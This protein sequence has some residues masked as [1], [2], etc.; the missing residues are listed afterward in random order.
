MIAEVVND[1]QL[2]IPE[3]VTGTGGPGTI[4][5][6]I[7]LA[8][9]GV[10]NYKVQTNPNSTYN[11]KVDAKWDVAGSGGSLVAGLGAALVGG[12]VGVGV[13][14]GTGILALGDYVSI[15]TRRTAKTKRAKL[16]ISSN[17]AIFL[18]VISLAPCSSR[19]CI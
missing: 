4:L 18:T 10:N 6:F 7:D 13:G 9:K 19:T 5:G 14:T 17:L 11:D 2:T 15:T 8:F 16:R 3:P 1:L 12:P